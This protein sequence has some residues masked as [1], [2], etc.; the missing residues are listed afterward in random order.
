MFSKKRCNVNFISTVFSRMWKTD[1][2]WEVKAYKHD[3]CSTYAGFSFGCEKDYVKVKS[4]LPWRFKGGLM[5]LEEWPESGQWEDAA[6]NAVPVWIKVAGFPMKAFNESNVHR[7]GGMEGNVIEVTWKNNNCMWLSGNAR[8]LVAFPVNRSIMVW[9]LGY[10]QKDYRKKVVTEKV[11]NGEIVQLYGDW[12]N[13]ENNVVKHCFDNNRKG[14]VDLDDQRLD[15]ELETQSKAGMGRRESEGRRRELIDERKRKDEVALSGKKGNKEAEV[16]KKK[17]GGRIAEVAGVMGESSKLSYAVDLEETKTRQMLNQITTETIEKGTKISR[18]K[19]RKVTGQTQGAGS[20]EDGVR[21]FEEYRYNEELTK[22]VN[23]GFVEGRRS[24]SRETNP[25]TRKRISI[26]KIA[27]E[28]GQKR[29]KEVPKGTTEEGKTRDNYGENLFFS[30]HILATIAEMGSCHGP[31]SGFMSTQTSPADDS[32]K[33]FHGSKTSVVGAWL[34]IDFG[35]VKGELTWSNGHEKGTIM[36]RLDRGLCNKDWNLSF[37]KASIK[38]LDWCSSDHRAPVVD[39]GVVIKDNKCGKIKRNLRFHFE[40]AW[41]D[42]DECKD[43]VTTSWNSILSDGSTENLKVKLSR[44][45]NFPVKSINERPIALIPKVERPKKMEEYMPI[46]LCNVAYKII[47]KCLANRLRLTLPEVISDSQSASV[48]NILIHDNAIIGFEGLHCMRKNNF[49]NGSK[50]VLK[51]DMAKAYDRVECIFIEE[52]VGSGNDIRVVEDPWIPR[53]VNLKLIEKPNIPEGMQVIDLKN[54]D[55]DWDEKFIQSNFHSDD[56]NLILSLATSN[57]EVDDKIMWHYSKNGEYSIK[58]GYKLASNL[59]LKAE[60]SNMKGIES[61]TSSNPSYNRCGDL[62]NERIIHALWRCE[63]VFPIWKRSD[64]WKIFKQVRTQDPW[65]FVESCF[66]MPACGVVDWC[67][68]VAVDLQD[69]YTIQGKTKEKSRWSPPQ[70][71]VWKVNVDA[72][73]YNMNGSCSSG[74]VIRDYS[75]QVLCSSSGFSSRPLSA[76]PA[77]SVAIISGLKLAL[78]AGVKKNR[79]ASDCLNAI[80][81]INNPSRSIS[82]VDNLLE[83]ITG[84]SCNFDLVEFCFELRDANLLAHSLAKLALKSKTSASWNR[85]VPLIV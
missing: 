12:L 52:R 64:F 63:A 47:S 22:I 29:R 81:L 53:L 14:E 11:G 72:G 5:I 68:L 24:F 41:C 70:V 79:V 20:K 76:L 26:K 69:Q 43:I 19:K 4:T 51:L 9:D 67:I 44:C 27:R 80:N 36:E 85:G 21:S 1:E 55:G 45:G 32:W 60:A 2:K 30:G 57:K 65:E 6:S 59:I 84:L 15:A 39:C 16:D 78:A 8:M 38:V 34:C 48:N 13:A 23:S 10:D 71:G 50:M 66:C 74:V 7:I 83:E 49:R 61:K 56:V 46:S 35:N 37:P 18:E 17:E 77:E 82:D 62:H 3:K 28:E 58:S 31:L 42:D 25:K 54:W 33:L 73:V 75:G 40:E